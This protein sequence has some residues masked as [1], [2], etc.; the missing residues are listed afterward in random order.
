MPSASFLFLLFLY[1]R[2][3]TSENILGTG[4]KFTGIIF[5]P[6][7]RRSPEGSLGGTPQAKGGPLSRARAHPR[8]GPAPARGGSPRPPLIRVKRIYNFLL[9]HACFVSLSHVFTIMLYHFYAFY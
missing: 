1:F 5:T 2:K 4:R 9:I 6:R 8:V 3:F 7:R